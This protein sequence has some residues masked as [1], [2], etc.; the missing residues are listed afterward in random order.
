VD[1]YSSAEIALMTVDFQ[2]NSSS[3]IACMRTPAL[4]ARR[5]GRS[6]LKPQRS[7]LEQGANL[8]HAL[9]APHR[10]R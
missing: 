1:L 6:G 9:L 5:N 10:Y 7:K 8:P 4:P 2:L 3:F